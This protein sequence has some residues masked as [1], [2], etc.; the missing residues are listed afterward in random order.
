MSQ[1]GSGGGG[2]GAPA[3]DEVDGDPQVNSPRPVTFE[4]RRKENFDK[5]NEELEKRR[6]ALQETLKKEQ[7]M[8]EAAE[9][10][11]A[12]KR[13]RIK[14]EQERR[15]QL[16]MEKQM[17]RQRE[18]EEEKEEQRKRALEQREAARRELERQRQQEWLRQR[19]LEIEEKKNSEMVKVRI[20]DWVGSPRD[21]RGIISMNK[22][23]GQWKKRISLRIPLSTSTDKETCLSF[24]Y[25]VFYC[26]SSD[27]TCAFEAVKVEIPIV[28][29]ETPDSSNVV[30]NV[31][32][33]Q[34]VPF[35]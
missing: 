9:R 21:A 20:C 14:Q 15:R 32:V 16:E 7:A 3:T 17:A 6:R 29:R 13:E 25:V 18:I 23:D 11:E 22:H 4:D 27:G 35:N 12:E 33:M 2:G 1:P 10:A 31:K 24:N 28:A 8:R 34:K 30:K 26:R 19:K 5:G